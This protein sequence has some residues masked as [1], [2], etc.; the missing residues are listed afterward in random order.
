[1]VEQIHAKLTN[2]DRSFLL[3]FKS[4]TPD[5]NRFLVKSVSEVPAVQWKLRNIERFILANSKKHIKMLK[6]LENCLMR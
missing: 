6:V 3:S 5:W 2:D 1:M 4:R